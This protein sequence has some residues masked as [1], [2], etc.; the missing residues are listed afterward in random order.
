MKFF[1]RSLSNAFLAVLFTLFL[2]CPPFINIKSAVA[3]TLG[4]ED[5]TCGY[6]GKSSSQSYF[7]SFSFPHEP[8]LD[9]QPHK[10]ILD[11]QSLK[12]CPHCGYLAVDFSAPPSQAVRATF[13]SQAYADIAKENPPEAN[14]RF[15]RA[16]FLEEADQDFL[17]AGEHLADVAWCFEVGE[18]LYWA[19]MK[20]LEAAENGG[21]RRWKDDAW[22][23]VNRSDDLPRAIT[24]PT[25]PE[26]NPASAA[27]AA[28]YR[29]RA[30][31]LLEKALAE[32]REK[33]GEY[34]GGLYQL[35]EFYRRAGDFPHAAQAAKQ[36]REEVSAAPKID[37]AERRGFNLFLDIQEELIRAKDASR[38]YGL[39][40]EKRM[41]ESETN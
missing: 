24:L 1:P 5:M 37:K 8:G 28:E 7:N 20:R 4:E 25:L 29:A 15:L 33:E 13:A 41:K 19:E 12:E 21:G 23:E 35:V 11:S 31:P 34:F 10:L 9:L 26:V 32:P 3:T 18:E 27:K 22:Y 36:A 17:H 30:I 40:I 2:L 38:H 16:A 14:L 39:H 6:C